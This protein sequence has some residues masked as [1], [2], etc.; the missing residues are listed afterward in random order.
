MTKVDVFAEDGSGAGNWRVMKV[1]KKQEN[2]QPRP[3]PKNAGRIK[4][5]VIL[6]K[7][8]E[9]SLLFFI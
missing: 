2:Q 6:L 9:A 3:P 4:E 1:T 5:V 7:H 8:P